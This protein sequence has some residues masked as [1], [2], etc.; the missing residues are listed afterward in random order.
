MAID[1]LLQLLVNE[2]RIDAERAAV[3]A[4]HAEREH[5]GVDTSLLALGI[6]D[7]PTLLSLLPRAWGGGVADRARLAGATTAAR[8]ALPRAT[9]EEHRFVPLDISGRKLTVACCVPDD[10]TAFEM[11]L[12]EVGFALSLYLR[13]LW[14]TEPLN[15]R[16]LHRLYGTPV[17]QRLRALVDG[18]DGAAAVVVPTSSPRSTTGFAMALADDVPGFSAVAEAALP[19]RGAAYD[20]VDEGDLAVV[21]VDEGD[22]AASTA[23]PLADVAWSAPVA[24][25]FDAAR[26]PTPSA[27]VVFPALT[28]DPSG[29]M[30]APRGAFVFDAGPEPS[31]PVLSLVVDGT[32]VGPRSDARNVMQ[33]AAP[34]P[35]SAA[36]D[37][38]AR[39]RRRTKVLWNIEDAAAEVALARTRD[40]L[41]DVACRFAWRRLHSAAV[42]VRQA[43]RLIVWDILDPNHD[44]DALRGFP[45]SMTGDHALARAFALAGPSVGPVDG[46]DPL[47]RLLG[48]TPHALLVVP[49]AV[50]GR[51]A[52]AVIGDNGERSV[53]ATIV[54]EL[55]RLAP[56]LGAALAALIVRQKRSASTLPVSVSV[57]VSVASTSTVPAPP[58]A[59]SRVASPVDAAGAA[60]VVDDLDE[61]RFTFDD[62]PLL[63]TRAPLAPPELAGRDVPPDI[64]VGALVSSPSMLPASASDR[65]VDQLPGA[66]AKEAVLLATWRRWIDAECDEFDADVSLL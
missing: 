11:A 59:S 26:V 9:A 25:R 40:E 17:P 15:A 64:V 44:G 53:P 42:V 2:R 31:A 30:I 38:A 12:D 16:E 49:V 23:S 24:T 32:V 57:S 19:S 3:V 55:Q 52:A 35:T 54:A 50:G 6:V 8:V 45:L 63:P 21:V 20:V 62:G 43:D 47:C 28:P 36:V 46:D 39:Q 51:V 48:R 18:D 4:A 13:P 58:S 33:S 56:R 37:A 1:P 7:E 5:L 34:A 29:W 27:A 61:L 22:L 65:V 41:L 66:Y 10:L 14:T 60:A